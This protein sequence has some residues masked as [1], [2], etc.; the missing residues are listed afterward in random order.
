MILQLGLFLVVPIFLFAAMHA[1]FSLSRSTEAFDYPHHAIL[2]VIFA[3]Y[4]SQS[5]RVKTFYK[6]SEEEKL[7]IEI[8]REKSMAVAQGMGRMYLVAMLVI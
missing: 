6:I 8:S 3:D 7:S 4:L 5:K 2:P 1:L